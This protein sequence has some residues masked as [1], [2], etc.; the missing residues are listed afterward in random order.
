MLLKIFRLIAILEGI[1]YLLLFGVSMPLKHIAKMPE[2]NI[3]IGY[4]HG[5]LFVAYVI[6]ALFICKKFN[7]GIKRFLLLFIA[8]LLPFGTFYVDAKYLK[9]QLQ[10]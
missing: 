8:A 10:F 6:L 1:S 5:F 7:W 4:C 9:P 2:P 3:I